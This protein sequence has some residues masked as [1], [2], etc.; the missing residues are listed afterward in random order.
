MRRG[1]RWSHDI[2]GCLHLTCCL[3]NAAMFL[4]KIIDEFGSV[5]VLQLFFCNA[6]SVQKLLPFRIDVV[7]LCMVAMCN[8]SIK[9]Q[10][11]N[12]RNS[13]IRMFH[14]HGLH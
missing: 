5:L 11:N 6:D 8:T 10:S 9:T 2:G 7:T 14:T 4:H 12:G 13:G 3:L 1:G